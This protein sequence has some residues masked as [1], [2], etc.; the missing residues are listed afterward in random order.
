MEGAGV[1][2]NTYWIRFAHGRTTCDLAVENTRTL[3]QAAESAGVGRIVHF[4][5]TNAT[6]S[7]LPYFRAMAQVGDML[8]G[9]GVPYAIIRPTWSLAS[10]SCC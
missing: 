3:P 4:S 10:R 8:E 9:L 5:A 7:R 2:Y 1:L 6:S